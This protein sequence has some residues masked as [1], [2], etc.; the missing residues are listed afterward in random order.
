[1]CSDLLAQ[2]ELRG[3]LIR[4]DA[5]GC[6]KS[7]AQ[8]VVEAG[9]DYVLALKDNPPTLCEDVALW[10]K[11][12]NEQGH[13]RVSE[14]LDKD[15]GRIEIRRTVVSQEIDWLEQRTE[16][17]GLKAL[18]RVESTRI[19]GEKRTSEHRDDLCSIT[20]PQR[21]AQAI[22]HHWRIE[23]EQHWVLDMQF[24]E[25]ANRARKDHSAANLGLIRRAA[26]NLLRHA[27][28]TSTPPT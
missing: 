3:A 1:M 11:T 16:W 22:G 7:I 5:M 24:G 28:D 9:G 20:D 23:N 18:A 8:A 13:V 17:A 26:L 14:P 4:I 27:S 10:L 12:Q 25:D 21:I 2:R 6:Q 15:H 19:I